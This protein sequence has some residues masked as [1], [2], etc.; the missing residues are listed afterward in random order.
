MQTYDG[1]SVMYGHINGAQ[2][3]VRREYP[4]ATLSLCSTAAHRLNLFLC[5]SAPTI[6]PV[7]IFFINTSAFSTSTSNTFTSSTFNS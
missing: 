7:K 2:T 5:Q 3:L 6:A 1:A 4:F